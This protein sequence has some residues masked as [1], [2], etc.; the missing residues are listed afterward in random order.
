MRRRAK[1]SWTNILTNDPSFT[2]W[3]W[4]V[5]NEKG[6]VLEVGCIKTKP[7]DKKLRIRKGDDRVRRTGELVRELHRV[8]NKYNIRY[9]LSELPHGSQNAQ[10]AFLL[11]A[12]AAIIKTM[13]D[14]LGLGIEWYSE[15]DAKKSVTNKK[16]IT[17]DE[18]VSIIA[19]LYEV[20][21]PGTKWRNQG[22]ADALAVYHVAYKESALLKY[23]GL[24][25]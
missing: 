22:I 3:G 25:L 1:K 10:A 4:A 5:L 12:A 13:A 11:G 19:D 20:P 14:V 9:L 24:G 15:E 18:M 21:W 8:V 23:L 6:I 17:K 16:S 7:V 2:A